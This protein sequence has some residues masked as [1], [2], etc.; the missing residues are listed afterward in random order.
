MSSE[1]NTERAFLH[2]ISNQ[3]VIAQGMGSFVQKHINEHS[4]PD[5][6]EVKRIEKAM[7]AVNKLIEMVKERREFV[8]SQQ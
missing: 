6:K 5:S 4:D 7:N 1:E 2:D 8:K 3:L